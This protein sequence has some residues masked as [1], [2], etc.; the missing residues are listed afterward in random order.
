[1]GVTV[2]AEEVAVAGFTRTTA[3][4]DGRGLA[5]SRQQRAIR[6]VMAGSTGI[7][8]FIIGRINRN[9]DGRTGDCGRGMAGSTVGGRDHT[10]CVI[11]IAVIHKICAM[12]G[13]TIAAASWHGRG[14]AVGRTQCT[15]SCVTGGTGV[16]NLIIVAVNR[17][18]GE[19]ASNGR[20][21]MTAIAVCRIHNAA[22]VVGIAVVRKICTVTGLTGPAAGRHVRCLTIGSL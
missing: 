4:R 2:A 5:V 18:T 15:I 13:V 8:D 10:R 20:G 11:G 3:S 16:M 1:M 19:C 21:K 9:T 22:A 14:L 12:T 6:G 17:D 7:M